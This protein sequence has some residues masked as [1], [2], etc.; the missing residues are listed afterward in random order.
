MAWSTVAIS[1]PILVNIS[2]LSIFLFLWD[3]FWLDGILKK[4]DYI[5]NFTGKRAWRQAFQKKAPV[6]FAE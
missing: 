6:S 4:R 1:G 2:S 3:V 5:L